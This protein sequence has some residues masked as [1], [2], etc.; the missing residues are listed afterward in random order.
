MAASTLALKP[1]VNLGGSCEQDVLAEPV[2][3]DV[4]IGEVPCGSPSNMARNV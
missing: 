4:H 2:R 3:E 1:R